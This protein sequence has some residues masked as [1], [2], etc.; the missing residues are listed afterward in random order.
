MNI[1]DEGEDILRKL[2]KNEEESIDYDSLFFKTG[3]RAIK[4]NFLKRF[5]ALYD[6]LIDLLNEQISNDKM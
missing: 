4:F 6:L 1:A 2:D 3:D 5:G